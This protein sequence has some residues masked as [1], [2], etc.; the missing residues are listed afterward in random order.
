[1]LAGLLKSIVPR[2][3]VASLGTAHEEKK[4]LEAA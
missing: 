4:F 3:A 2:A 1:V